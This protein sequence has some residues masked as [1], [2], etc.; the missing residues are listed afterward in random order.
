M[1]VSSTG[2][3]LRRVDYGDFD[4]VLTF[5]TRD[6]GKISAIAK[7]AK[8]STKRFAGVLELFSLLRIVC[9][10]S[11][12]G[13]LPVLQEAAVKNPFAEI[14]SDVRKTAHASYWAELVTAWFEESQPQLDVY[15]LLNHSL[16]ALDAGEIPAGVLSVLFQIRFL[17]FSGHRPNLT[18]CSR[19]GRDLEQ[20]R[21]SRVLFD[22][23]RGGLVC[24]GCS[25]GHNGK[26]RLRRGTLKQLHWL[27]TAAL[28]KTG[29]MRFTPEALRE[30]F[31]FLD[32]FLP[33]HLGREP[34]SLKF[35]RQIR[36]G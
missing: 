10:H 19:C 36:Q 30:S 35:L 7:S 5:F 9:R 1:I 23:P 6:H 4:L 2:F 16:R 18:H 24:E 11:S 33:Y 22:L 8:K 13:G 32:A 14:R 26:I 34:K 15:R 25:L 28:S 21:E 20:F 12:R 27:E 31:E 29:R 17:I 3:V